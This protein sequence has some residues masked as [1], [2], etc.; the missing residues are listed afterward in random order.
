MLERLKADFD[1]AILSFF[2]GCAVLGIAPF[3]LYRLL[4]GE[5]RLGV[6]DAL[7]VL[8]I[9]GTVIYAWSSGDTRRAGL[10]LACFNTAG[11]VATTLLF[12]HHGLLW[13]YVVLVTNFFLTSRKAA[14]LA[15][16]GMLL[17]LVLNSGIF[18]SRLELVSFTVTTVLVMIYTYLFALRTET[19]RAQLEVLAT[20]DALTN[21]GNRRL[22]EIELAQATSAREP[23]SLAIFDLDHFK[24]VNDEFGHEAGDQ[25]LA[26][27]ARLLL[28]GTRKR[29]RLYRFGG[30]EFVLLMPATDASGA[31]TLLHELQGLIRRRLRSPGGPVSVSVGCASWR[32]GEDWSRW[33]ARADAAMYVAKRS[34]RDQVVID[35]STVSPLAVAQRFSD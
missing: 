23:R 13:V 19:Q 17:A 7:I 15:N 28:Q 4:G 10:L 26:E 33:L 8:A 35:D 18:T 32:D 29:D 12:G 5:Y 22:M 3:A 1:L 30:E 20:R 11:C 21:T 2:G 34:G 27:F 24:Q 25:V 31:A 6:V 16:L 14:A 9:I